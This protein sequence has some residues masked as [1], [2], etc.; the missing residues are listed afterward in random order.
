MTTILH[1]PRRYRQGFDLHQKAIAGYLTLAKSHQKLPYLGGPSPKGFCRLPHFGQIPPGV[2]LPWPTFTKRLPHLGQI[3]PGVALP[4]PTLT[5]RLPH[6]GQIAPRVTS[7]WPTFTKRLLQSTSPWP[8][9][10]RGECCH[11][12]IHPSSRKKVER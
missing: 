1:C 3:P 5:K 4:W 11:P 7:P 8:S 2:T 10:L 12:H 9:S 6:L